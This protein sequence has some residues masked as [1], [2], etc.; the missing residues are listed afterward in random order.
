MGR[1]QEH[2]RLLSVSHSLTHPPIHPPSTNPPAHKP[3]PQPNTARVMDYASGGS[4]FSYL[5]QRQR[6]KEPLA[7]W[8]FQQ[9]LLAVDY[10]H[11]K[12][13]GGPPL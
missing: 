11:K 12:V 6:L 3:Q 9:L 8:F 1:A 7:R 2:G 13:G 5:Q 4:L 10:C